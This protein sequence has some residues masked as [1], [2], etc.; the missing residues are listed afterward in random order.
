MI[1]ATQP[2]DF[3]V[4]TSE[5]EDDHVMIVQDSPQSEG[6]APSGTDDQGVMEETVAERTEKEAKQLKG[7]VDTSNNLCPTNL[8]LGFEEERPSVETFSLQ[9][10]EG[11]DRRVDDHGI[12]SIV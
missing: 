3:H 8:V 2:K 12:F 1:E 9:L 11:D 6:D 4:E 5:V 7:V 10:D